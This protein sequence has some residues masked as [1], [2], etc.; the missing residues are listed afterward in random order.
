MYIKHVT[1]HQVNSNYIFELA[2]HFSNRYGCANC[3]KTCNRLC[4]N[5]VTWYVRSR[6]FDCFLLVFNQAITRHH[7]YHQ[8]WR[9][10]LIGTFWSELFHW[11]TDPSTVCCCIWVL[12]CV[13][14][15]F[16]P[17]APVDTINVKPI[18][19]ASFCNSSSVIPAGVLTKAGSVQTLTKLVAPQ[20]LFFNN[21]CHIMAIWLFWGNCS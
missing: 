12:H 7:L 13:S 6:Y 3:N 8:G 5:E 10:A 21:T 2:R 15:S 14:W 9:L 1:V 17:F 19:V 20:Q 18:N 16:D 11:K 4:H